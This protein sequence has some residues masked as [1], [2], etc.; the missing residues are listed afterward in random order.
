MNAQ[1]STSERERE[2]NGNIFRSCNCSDWIAVIWLNHRWFE[3]DR[4]RTRIKQLHKRIDIDSRKRQ[5]EQL[6][7]KIDLFLSSFI[8]RFESFQDVVHAFVE[9]YQADQQVDYF[10]SNIELF[11]WELTRQ[12]DR[13]PHL[14]KINK[15]FKN[16][17]IRSFYL[18]WTRI[19]KCFFDFLNSR[20]S[21]TNSTND[22]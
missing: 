4:D 2:R 16:N 6:M 21:K 9:R 13:F 17:W 22:V 15:H 14:N 3:R 18:Q 12:F 19:G 7:N 20:I 1:E 8:Q 11:P 10:R 5:N